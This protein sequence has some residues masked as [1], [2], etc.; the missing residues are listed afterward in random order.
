MDEI[1]YISHVCAKDGIPL[2]LDKNHGMEVNCK[3]MADDWKSRL[4]VINAEK[5]TI[6]LLKKLQ[7]GLVNNGGEMVCFPPIEEDIEKLLSRGQFWTAKDCKFSK[8][9]QSACHENS[10]LLWEANQEKLFLA[11]G[12]ALSN[13]GLWRQHSWCIQN[14]KEGNPKVI[15]TTEPRELYYGFVMTLSETEDFGY[16][17]TF[18]GLD[19]KPKTAQKYGVKPIK[20]ARVKL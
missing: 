7:E 13:D 17:N 4:E 8:G 16:D 15:E 2:V 9:R 3:P 19:I 12:Y 1:E 10:S 6:P 20:T 11:T 5:P 18:G 14:T